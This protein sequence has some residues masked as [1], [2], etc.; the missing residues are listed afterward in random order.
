[1]T[2]PKATTGPDIVA[3]RWTDGPATS[4]S[5]PSA[6]RQPMRPW[7]RGRRGWSA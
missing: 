3:L 7:P 2:V 4:T 6:V 1:M 5:P